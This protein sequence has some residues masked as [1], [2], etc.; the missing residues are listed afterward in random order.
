M[1]YEL[2]IVEE[3]IYDIKDAFDYYESKRKGL[4]N[5]FIETIEYYIQRIQNYPEHF[6]V[7]RKPYREAYI[8][9]FPFIIIYEIKS[10]KVT[11]YSIF[12][13]YT[14]PIKKPTKK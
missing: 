12:N 2:E 6:Q 14:N 5:R 10:K 1:K 11:V 13:T 8:R 7:K 3:A 9:D 4:G